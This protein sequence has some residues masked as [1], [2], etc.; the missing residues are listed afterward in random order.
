MISTLVSCFHFH[1]YNPPSLYLLLLLLLLLFT[2]IYSYLLYNKFGD[3]CVISIVN[4]I[5]GYCVFVASSVIAEW[6]I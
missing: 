2:L 3:P 4:D 6:L 5:P 1:T